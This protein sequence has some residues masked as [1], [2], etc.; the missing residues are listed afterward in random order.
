ML[1]WVWVGVVEEVG[2]LE[3]SQICGPDGWELSP[4]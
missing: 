4:G 2:I 3:D 1:G